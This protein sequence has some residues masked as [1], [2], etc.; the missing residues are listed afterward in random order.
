MEPIIA[1]SYFGS[2]LG[3]TYLIY[4][5]ISIH[6]IYKFRKY[7]ESMFVAK[8]NPKIVLVFV[9]SALFFIAFDRP[10]H[11]L[12]YTCQYFQ[13][14]QCETYSNISLKITY[15]LS[16]SGVSSAM[17]IRIWSVYYDI[18]FNQAIKFA[19]WKVLFNPSLNNTNWFMKHNKNL[20]NI[21]FISKYIIIPIFSFIYIK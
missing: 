21:H 18:K 9:A 14:S 10:L 7:K 8:R 16:T 5:P 19:K 17:L 6:Y 2:F 1:W 20:G 11:F 15:P 13:H 3:L 4:V 12:Y